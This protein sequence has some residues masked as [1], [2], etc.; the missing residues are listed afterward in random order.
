MD[1]LIVG[2]C[3]PTLQA[4]DGGSVDLIFADPPFNI[5]Y[6]YDLHN[7]R[8]KREEY[9]GWSHQWLRECVRLLRRTGSLFVAISDESCA[10]LKLMLDQ[11]GLSFRNWII[12]KYTFGRHQERRFGR[13][14]THILYYTAHPDRFIFNAE[15]IRIE[16]ERQRLGDRRANPAGRVPGD[17]WEGP[18][19]TGNNRER[20]G[21]PCQM[22]ESILERIIRAA[23]NVGDL[24]FDPFAGSGTTLAVAKRLGRRWLG[25]EISP[26]YAAAATQRIGKVRPEV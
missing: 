23:S 2:D 6:R 16:S 24:V 22:P 18:R 26:A 10:E 19:L 9:L 7:D 13:D 5:G 3:L 8:Q 20:T 14:H 21:H 25:C 15:D 4:M 17:V 12:W 1:G 11:F